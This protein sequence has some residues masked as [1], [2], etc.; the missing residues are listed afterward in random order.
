MKLKLFLGTVIQFR[1]CK[2]E[3][4]I[5]FTLSFF[6]LFRL[7]QFIPNLSLVQSYRIFQLLSRFDIVHAPTVSLRMKIL[8]PYFRIYNLRSFWRRVETHESKR[9]IKIARSRETISRRLGGKFPERSIERRF[10]KLSA[11]VFRPNRKLCFERMQCRD[12]C[13]TPVLLLTR[14]CYY[15]FPCSRLIKEDRSVSD[16]KRG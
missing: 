3:I 16:I 11:R 14:Q 13:Q 6:I 4:D 8:I 9:R 12:N 5:I 7:Y 1:S 15:L 2:Y 10:L